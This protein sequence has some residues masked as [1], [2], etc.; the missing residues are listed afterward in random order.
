MITHTYPHQLAFHFDYYES[1]NNILI[2]EKVQ[3]ST[4]SD[5]RGSIGC[6]VCKIVLDF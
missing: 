1:G 5:L 6:G 4:L 3:G 2:Q